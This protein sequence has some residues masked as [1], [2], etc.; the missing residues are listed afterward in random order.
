LKSNYA[1]FIESKG[2]N[3]TTYMHVTKVDTTK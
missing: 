3:Y 2:K 1:K